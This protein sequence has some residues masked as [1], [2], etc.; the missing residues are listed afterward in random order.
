MKTEDDHRWDPEEGED[1]N[2]PS[3][4]D[5]FEK[6]LDREKPAPMVV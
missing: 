3:D 1:G 5:A 6:K 2:L 4:E